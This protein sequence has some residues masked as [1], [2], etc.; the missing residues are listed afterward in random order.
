[1]TS[2]SPP[3]QTVKSDPWSGQQPYLKRGFEQAEQQLNAP[4]STV[5]PM[6]PYTQSAIGQ[7]TGPN[8]LI[9]SALNQAQQTISG[10]YFSGP[11][12]DRMRD[13]VLSSVQPG[14]DSAFS[15]G[16]R[17]GSGLHGEA[18][19]RGVSLGMTPFMDAERNRMMQATQM[20]PGLS[21]AGYAGNLAAG[22]LDQSQRQ[23][24]LSEPQNR[25]AQYMNLIGGGYGGTQTTTGGQG[26]NPLLGGMGGLAAGA[27]LASSLGPQGLGLMAAGSPWAWPMV[28]GGGLMGALG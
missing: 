3:S 9:D 8:P 10:D 26:G 21:Q 6:S 4:G 14:V 17:F 28:L 25:L 23:A 1:M 24:E 18:L 27:G 12:M 13:Y 16:G 2:K 5:A 20:A 7:M 15:S 22:Q 19:G 11:G